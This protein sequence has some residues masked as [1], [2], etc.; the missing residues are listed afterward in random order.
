MAVSDLQLEALNQSLEGCLNTDVA[1]RTLY[2]TDASLY[3]QLPVAVATP[4][5]VKDIQALV[6]FADRNGIGMIPRTAGTSLAG[7]VVG[8][9]IVVDVSRHFTKIIEINSRESWVR[10]QPGVIRDD[11]NRELAKHGLCFA[12]ETSTANRAMIGGMIGNN[13]CG[14]NSIVH[15]DTRKHVIELTGV[16]SDGQV[17][18]FGSVSPEQLNTLAQQESLKGN[19]YRCIQSIL[20]DPNNRSEIEN[21]FPKSSIGRRNTGYALDALIDTQPFGGSRGFNLCSL[22]T[23]SEGT[24]F[25]TTEAKLNC[26]AIPT[27]DSSVVCAHFA[28][29]NEA[30]LANIIAMQFSPSRCEL[31]DRHIIAGI[32]SNDLGGA[33]IEFI[34]NDPQAVLMIEFKDESNHQSASALAKEIKSQ[35]LGFHYPILTG[36]AARNAWTSRKAALGG[37]QNVGNA[38]T[39]VTIIEDAAVELQDL[40]KF[41]AE[42][43]E[44]LAN[45]IQTDCVVYGHAGAGELHLRPWLDM[46]Q[47]DIEIKIRDIATRFA[48]IVKSY[49]GALS[50]EHGSGRSRSE[51]IELMVGEQCYGWMQQ[52]K[53]AFDPNNIFN[54]GKVIEPVAM[55]AQLR[56]NRPQHTGTPQFRF[57][58]GGLYQAAARCSGSGDCRKSQLAGGTMCPSYHATRLEHDSTRARANLLRQSLTDVNSTSAVSD[59]EVREIMELCLSCKACKSEC[60]S[61]VDMAKMKA[62]FLHQYQ[63]KYGAPIRSRLLANFESW[64]ERVR[65]LG[66]V[67]RFA[68]T[69]TFVSRI[70]KKLLGVHPDRSLPDIKNVSLRQWFTQRESSSKHSGDLG[71]VLL[72]CDEFTNQIDVQVGKDAIELLELL[73]YEVSLL[74]NVESGRSAISLGMLDAAK[75]LADENVRRL[76]GYIDNSLPI[77]GVEPSALLTLRD[78]YPDLV[79]EQLQEQTSTLAGKVSLIEEFLCSE[80]ESGRITADRFSSETI[81]VRYHGHC[82]QKAISGTA[83]VLEVLSLP[84][85]CSTEEITAGCCGMA[86]FFGYDRD[87]FDLSQQIGEL[88]LFPA[89]RKL[90]DSTIVAA[91]GSSCRQQIKDATGVAAV[92]PLQILRKLVRNNLNSE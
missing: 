89:I 29:V 27:Q 30:L 44:F 84:E 58:E 48:K 20:T 65:R 55:D 66:T 35:G 72:F 32:R 23:G 25:F 57:H 9:G 33:G 83:A 49:G 12:P 60:P 68:S 15:G 46:Q 67:G 88:L 61:N 53:A 71:Q 63:N 86:G 92:H 85:N 1:T 34:Q 39:A 24:L 62:E 51:F 14:A 40:P 45:E 70:T 54:P 11:L 17:E 2:S 82:H 64:C 90:D 52:I 50:G 42:V 41:V 3:Q 81:Q 91:S 22:L 43:N 18:T 8:D 73:G 69:N 4:T 26:I 75:K 79:S 6:Q 77:I 16:T 76:S 28:S 56:A 80:I 21:S 38:K 7:Q 37:L 36:A 47:P 5:C 10:V 13:S 74:E 78:E 31:M 87:K 59:H 19:V